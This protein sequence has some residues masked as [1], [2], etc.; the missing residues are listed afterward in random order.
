MAAE[1]SVI[2]YLSSRGAHRIVEPL[3]RWAMAPR[4]ATPKGEKPDRAEAAR[5]RWEHYSIFRVDFIVGDMSHMSM[6]KK[7]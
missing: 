5:Q 3:S 2:G 7:K 6:S 4:S 1:S